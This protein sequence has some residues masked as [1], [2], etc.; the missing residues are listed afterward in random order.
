MVP[1]AQMKSLGE[2]TGVKPETVPVTRKQTC[3]LQWRPLL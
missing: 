1:A 3:W 2:D